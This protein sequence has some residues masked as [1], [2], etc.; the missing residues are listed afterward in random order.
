MQP[1][2]I[3]SS[4]VLVGFSKLLAV[5]QYTFGVLIN[6]YG[7]RIMYVESSPSKL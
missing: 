6:I 7:G 1:I 5:D 4:L 2:Y 3:Y